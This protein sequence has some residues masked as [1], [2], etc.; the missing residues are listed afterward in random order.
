MCTGAACGSSLTLGA[1]LRAGK[2]E[3]EIMFY[4]NKV[5]ERNE[6]IINMAGF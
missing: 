5:Q 4:L 2:I 3:R 6:Q 1:A